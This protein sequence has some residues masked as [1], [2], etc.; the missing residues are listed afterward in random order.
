MDSNN[1]WMQGNLDKLTL[2]WQNNEES[3]YKGLF[4]VKRNNSSSNIIVDDIPIVISGMLLKSIG[5]YNDVIIK[6]QLRSKDTIENDK[7]KVDL[8]VYVKEIQNNT[9]SFD[10][11]TTNSN[12]LV[13]IDGYICKRPN[14]RTTPSGKQITDLL[15]AC[16]YGKD[17]TAYIPAIA[18]GK[19]AR[20]ASRL[21]IGDYTH[22][23][24]KFQSRKYTKIIDNIPYDKV[25][26]EL[27]IDKIE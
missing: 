26:Y 22:V 13:N 18:W 5:I 19:Y 16:N 17:K 27:S 23:Q 20:Y 8:Y 4:K 25:A 15:I 10:S 7:L 11:T 14:L 21:K 24:G 3:F 2:I 6:G 9:L 1:V 12:N